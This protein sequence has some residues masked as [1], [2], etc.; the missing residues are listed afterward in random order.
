MMMLIDMSHHIQHF[1]ILVKQSVYTSVDSNWP[2]VV[3]M[4]EGWNTHPPWPEE[5]LTQDAK[6][7]SQ[8]CLGTLL[9]LQPKPQTNAC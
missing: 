4:F 6:A 2:I 1:A 3:D 9:M 7:D 8:K 5:R